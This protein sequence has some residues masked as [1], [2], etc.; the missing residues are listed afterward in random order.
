MLK[1]LIVDD[2]LSFRKGMY[3]VI[4]WEKQGF[5]VVGEAQDGVNALELIEAL[6][7]DVIL[8][9]IKMPLLDGMELIAIVKK[10][11]PNMFIIL[12]SG[13]GEFEYASKAINLNVSGYL[14]KPVNEN[15]LI[16]VLHQINKKYTESSLQ[17]STLF[18]MRDSID[19]LIPKI[20]QEQ[21]SHL[22]FDSNIEQVPSEILK[23]CQIDVKSYCNCVIFAFDNY[24]S[25]TKNLTFEE[26][27]QLLFDFRQAILKNVDD[28]NHVLID[29]N[30]PGKLTLFLWDS[31]INLALKV[32]SL[33]I[34]FRNEFAANNIHITCGISEVLYPSSM[35]KKA[36]LEACECLEYHFI[37][38][39]NEN[40]HYT[41][42]KLTNDT[43]C[44]DI[45]F[46][47]IS[48][49]SLIHLND[50]ALIDHKFD[51]LLTKI[52]QNQ[53]TAD[54]FKSFIVPNFY[55]VV[56]NVLADLGYNIQNVLIDAIK[57]YKKIIMQ[58]T[59][60]AMVNDLKILIVEVSNF[61]AKVK[62]NKYN[63]TIEQVKEY[64]RKNF[65]NSSL[66]LD[67]VARYANIS[68]NYLSYI[69]H[70][71][72]GI[73]FS[74]YLT[75]LRMEKSIDLLKNQKLFVYEIADKVGYNN[76]TWFSTSFKKYFSISPAEY[77][78]AANKKFDSIG[79]I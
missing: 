23:Q 65:S 38:S 55:L 34:R 76:T 73:T 30:D 33:I 37:A 10:N 42:L 63:G 2:E 24:S 72:E 50:L 40:I 3:K 46:Y 25:T 4:D 15:E 67:D 60:E 16:A 9:D 71:S 21:L 74:Q 56:Q 59:A 78:S 77:I 53:L 69:F 18:K 39:E 22:L 8:T 13:Y 28:L 32:D 57:T 7:P 70:Q 61:I 5:K 75:S 66:T 27:N 54:Y 47:D 45:S 52:K 26:K 14:L 64:M 29:L 44:L 49:N 79:T 12:L 62:T 68:T 31:N 1:V 36:Y 35:L 58:T 51:E 6:K 41:K 20:Q 17:R 43:H 48:I 19:K 11:Y